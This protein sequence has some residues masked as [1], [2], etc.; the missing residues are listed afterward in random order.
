ML[1]T[2]M[3]KVLLFTHVIVLLLGSTYAFFYLQCLHTGIGEM[4]KAAL[5]HNRDREVAVRSIYSRKPIPVRIHFLGLMLYFFLVLSPWNLNK[6]GF[7]CWNWICFLDWS[8][9]AFKGGWGAARFGQT[10]VPDVLGA[11]VKVERFKTAVRKWKWKKVGST[12]LFSAEEGFFQGYS[13]GEITTI[14]PAGR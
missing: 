13:N 10:S 1:N 14:P 9:L 8:H 3:D 4:T 2:L 5:A 12:S 6:N 7:S 11:C